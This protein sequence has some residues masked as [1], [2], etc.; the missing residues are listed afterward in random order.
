MPDWKIHLLFGCILAIFWFNVFY[1]GKF[2]TEPLKAIFLLFISL[3]STT[4]A[5]IDEKKSK[6]R[7]FISFVLS[8]SISVAYAFFYINTWYYAPFYFFILFFIFRFIP[9]KHRGFTH[10][11]K[12][13]V[14]FSVILTIIL[15]FIFTL[16]QNDVLL[17]FG[18]IFLSYNLHLF[19]DTL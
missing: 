1:F 17:W 16:S 12:F 18:M 3:F 15:Y 7:S 11:F 5:D 9:S 13:S 8:F 14:F 2:I 6:M 19:L 4:F 10:S